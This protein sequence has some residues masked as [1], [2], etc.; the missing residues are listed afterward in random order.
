MENLKELV[1]E[2]I[3]EFEVDLSEFVDSIQQTENVIINE[4][5]EEQ[6]IICEKIEN[7]VLDIT[8]LNI[9]NFSVLTNGLFSIVTPENTSNTNQIV[10]KNNK[11]SQLTIFDKNVKIPFIK[12]YTIKSYSLLLKNTNSNDSYKFNLSKLNSSIR[13][14]L[15]LFN[16]HKK[17]LLYLYRN[18]TTKTPLKLLSY[19]FGEEI[20]TKSVTINSE[21]LRDLN[22]DITET[23]KIKMLNVLPKLKKNSENLKKLSQCLEK[24]SDQLNKTIDPLYINKIYNLMINICSK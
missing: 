5:K 21:N 2:N 20:K 7:E 9:A 6:N 11:T 14:I 18:D 3:N 24:I 17:T 8:N 1:E 13:G 4:A 10:V 19:K 12:D 23:D 15:Y 22:E 16:N